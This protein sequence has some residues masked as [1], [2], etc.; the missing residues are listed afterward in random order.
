MGGAKEQQ[1]GPETV[2]G[3]PAPPGSAAKFHRGLDGKIYHHPPMQERLAALG[4]RFRNALG[5]VSTMVTLPFAAT[6]L[7]LCV[8]IGFSLGGMIAA[9]LLAA[10]VVA[11][12]LI[13][14]IYFLVQNLFKGCL[15]YTSDAAD[16]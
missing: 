3:V 11:L 15:L 16:E 8:I 10:L 5:P 7:W 13:V 2:S 1:A 9:A 14:G 6:A 12:T 4:G